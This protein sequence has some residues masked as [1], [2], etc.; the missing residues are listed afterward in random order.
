MK[1]ILF[2][3]LLLLQAISYGQNKN[4]GGV[5]VRGIVP[6]KRS[7]SSTSASKFQTPLTNTTLT[8]S[9]PTGSSSEVGITEGQLNV[10]PTGGATYDIP[11]NMAPG[12][13]GVMPQI[14]LSYNSQSGNGLVGYGWNISGIS[15][16][17]RMPS[18][19]F[20]DDT[21]DAVDFDNLDRFAFDGQRLMVKNGTG[22]TYGASGAIYETENFSNIK[23]TSS[24]V[25]PNGASYGPASFLVEYPDGSFAQYGATTNSTS[26][27][28]WA[29]TYWQN[30]QGVRISYDY[31]LS[32]NSLKINSIKYGSIGAATGLNEVQFVYKSRSRTENSYVGGAEFILNSILS[33]IHVLGN[34]V[35]FRHYSLAHN[36]TSLGYERLISITEKSGDNAKNLNPTVFTYED[37]SN[38]ISVSSPIS[39]IATSNTTQLNTAMISGD[40]TGKGKMDFILYP[41]NGENDRQQY[42]LFTDVQE[43]VNADLGYIHNVGKFDKIFPVS[44]LGGS[45]GSG[46]KLMPFQ[47]WNVVKT[48]LQNVTTFTTY[49]K[50]VT[51][52]IYFQDEKSY[53]FPKFISG[54]SYQCSQG[55]TVDPEDPSGPI[56]VDVVKTIPKEYLNGDYNG[57]GI[58]D[59]IVIEKSYT[60]DIKIGC[61]THS[62]T[63]NPG[64]TYFVNL[65]RRITSNY[66]TI[67]GTV[68]VTLNSKFEVA[69]VNGDGKSDIL[70]F[71]EGKVT[72]Y[73]LK[74]N[75]LI[76]ELWRTNDSDI[77][78]AI[79]KPFL[80]E[81]IMETEKRTL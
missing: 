9:S 63:N 65:D 26:I 78:T 62:V 17:T 77:S 15:S 19:K 73:T 14:S 49:S 44:W 7:E 47:G 70:I 45:S 16:I 11:I 53:Q 22:G 13:N 30:P 23:I 67:S 1:K 58:T 25:H 50:G 66:V 79:E 33:E 37:L 59:V 64:V 3:F 80:L 72:V 48:S 43:G 54:Y 24:G 51:N 61:N 74:D 46:Y 42:W 69:D 8:P 27:T 60:Y 41:I 36:V 5:P 4:I 40:F 10:S 29:I 21:I 52:P 31:I 18:T 55:K 28:Q 12:I 75:N 56:W 34:G 81:I 35:G 38:T 39:F 68:D 32:N 20:H 2:A 57:D 71:N 76:E 6:I